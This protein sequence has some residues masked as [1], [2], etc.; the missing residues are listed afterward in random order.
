MQRPGLAVGFSAWCEYHAAGKRA[1][2]IATHLRNEAGL[3]GEASALETELH[4]MRAGYEAKLR[5]AQEDKVMALERQLVEL[6]GSAEE[7]MALQAEREKEKRVELLRR[8]IVR[9]VMN[10]GLANGWAA[11]HEL[12]SAKTYAMGRLREVGNRMNA[13]YLSGAFVY[14]MRT[15]E[16]GRRAAEIEAI[17]RESR[18]V[19][20]QLRRA[21]FENGQLELRR[22]ALEDELRANKERLQV[23]MRE[24][25]GKCVASHDQRPMPCLL[26]ACL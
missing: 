25:D 3:Q 15:W 8:Q 23:M 20:A 2:I 1:K 26:I 16:K 7:R 5:A 13:P 18:S 12:W 9:R 19:E 6:T 11:W 17:E 4:S 22:V 14:W 10:A 21:R 24:A